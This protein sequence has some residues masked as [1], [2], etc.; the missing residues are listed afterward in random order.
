MN[1]WQIWKHC[2]HDMWYRITNDYTEGHHAP[3]CKCPLGNR[4]GNKARPAIAILHRSLEGI[5]STKLGVDDDEPNGPVNS[6]CQCDEENNPHGKTGLSYGIWLSNDTSASISYSATALPC[7]TTANVAATYMILFAIFMNALLMPLLGLAL[8]SK[9][10]TL[11]SKS[12]L[13]TVTLGASM[14]VNNGALI[15]G[16]LLCS[17]F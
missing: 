9:S 15:P 8:S 13:A 2:N 3:E 6:D 11:K 5:G 16:L 17:A 7:R 10:S 14:S 4:Y 12:A 1:I